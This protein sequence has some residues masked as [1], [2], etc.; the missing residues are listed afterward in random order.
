MAPTNPTQSSSLEGIGGKRKHITVPD[1]HGIQRPV[2]VTEF[3]LQYVKA[4]VEKR[5]QPFIRSGTQAIGGGLHRSLGSVAS[6][7]S[8]FSSTSSFNLQTTQTSPLPRLVMLMLYPILFYFCHTFIFCN[9][10]SYSCVKL[11][12]F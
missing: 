3:E 1:E 11:Y 8:L 7:G 4:V 9:N 12:Q 10:F 5:H 2:A 6:G